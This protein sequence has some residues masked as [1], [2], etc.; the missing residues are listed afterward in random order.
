MNKR[1]THRERPLAKQIGWHCYIGNQ[2]Y[3][4]EFQKHISEILIFLIF[5]KWNDVSFA[6]LFPIALDYEE[7]FKLISINVIA[8]DRFHNNIPLVTIAT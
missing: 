5:K 4:N 7:I 1:Q 2:I 6:D 8:N 3:A